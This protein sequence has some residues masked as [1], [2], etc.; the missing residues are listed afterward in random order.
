[1]SERKRKEKI[2]KK[3]KK[4]VGIMEIWQRLGKKKKNKRIK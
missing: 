4:F 3:R 2:R 1:M